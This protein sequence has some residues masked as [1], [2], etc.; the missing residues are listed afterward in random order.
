MFDWFSLDIIYWPVS[1]IMWAWYKAFALLLCLLEFL[2]V[3]ALV[4]M[5]LVLHAARD[6]VQAVRPPDPTTRQMRELQ[7]QIKALQKKYG[8]PSGWR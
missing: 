7:P 4:V 8:A 5:F 1:A 2:R 3:D 6:A